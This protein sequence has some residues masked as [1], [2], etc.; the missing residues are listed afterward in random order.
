MKISIATQTFNRCDFFSRDLLRKQMTTT[1]RLA[2]HQHGT[3]AAHADSA[4]FLCANQIQVIAQD[5][6]QCPRVC[7]DFK[8]APVY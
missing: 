7:F 1:E 8:L 5:I 3:R 2:I 6:E 4:A